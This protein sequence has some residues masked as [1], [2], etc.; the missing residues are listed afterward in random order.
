[1]AHTVLVLPGEH[2]FQVG[3]GE[4]VLDAALRQAVA[5]PYGCRNGSCG[6]CMGRVVEGRIDYPE[7]LPGAITP[8]QAEAGQALFCQAVP[9]SDLVIEAREASEDEDFPVRSLPTRVVAHEHLAHDVIR[10]YL[11]LPAT[12]R[13]RFRAGQYINILMKD[14]RRRAFSLANAPH[15][16]ARLELHI[17]HVPGG[18][19]TDFVFE[20][21]RDKAVLRIEGPLGGFF[22]REESTRPI[23][24][25]A[26][27]T[28]FAP[29]KG[30]IEHALAAGI[31]RPMHL[32][33]GVRARRDLYLDGLAREWAQRHALVEYVPV[34]SEPAPE[35]AWE[36]RT[37][38]VHT[39]IA[40]DFLDLSGYEV[41]AGGPPQ[42][43]SAGR[44]AFLSRGLPPEH[45]YADA[46][47]FAKDG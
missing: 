36:G 4:S 25:M 12:E 7:G 15:E 40:T 27:G 46:F 31:E 26:G 32:Y 37:G 1:M 45:Y 16:D 39:A 11:K 2:R 44:E 42:M 38:L 21:L 13:L 35:D 5:L 18:A 24:F 8:E 9:D 22:L 30:I 29:I 41:Y 34:L 14:G 28:G 10:L 17:R 33:W 20:Q 19:F 23:V 47:E 3:A 43:V 6:S